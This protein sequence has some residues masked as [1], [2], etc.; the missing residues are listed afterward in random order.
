MPTITCPTCGHPLAERHETGELG[1]KGW[2]DT[3]RLT[4]DVAAGGMRVRDGRLWLRCPICGAWAEQPDEADDGRRDAGHTGQ[5]R[6]RVS[7]G[8]YR[9]TPAAV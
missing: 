8:G 6:G 3:L 7:P 1:Q 4:P 9:A 5:A 2:R